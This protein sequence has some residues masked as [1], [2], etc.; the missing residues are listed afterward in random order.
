[1]ISVSFQDMTSLFFF[2]ISSTIA[3]TMITPKAP[4]KIPASGRKLIVPSELTIT[5]AFFNTAAPIIGPIN[6]GMK[7]CDIILTPWN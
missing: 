7:T 5:S 6:P 3:S 4:R 2:I 1:M